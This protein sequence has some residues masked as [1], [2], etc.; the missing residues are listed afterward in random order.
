MGGIKH[1]QILMYKILY[2]LLCENETWKI[3]DKQI[4]NHNFRCF[5]LSLS[6]LHTANPKESPARCSFMLLCV[7]EKWDFI[8]WKIYSFTEMN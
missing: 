5:S 6:S 3:S 2:D 7:H 8:D 4:N 1:F